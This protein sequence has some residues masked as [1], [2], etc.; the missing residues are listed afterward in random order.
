MCYIFIDT[1]EKG[2]KTFWVKILKF[3]I[4]NLDSLVSRALL[5]Q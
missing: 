3:N 2:G 4:V 1:N 5:H